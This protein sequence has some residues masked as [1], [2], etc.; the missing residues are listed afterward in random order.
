M[1]YAI[2]K[3]GLGTLKKVLI[4]LYPFTLPKRIVQDRI[5]EEYK[6]FME[7]KKQLETLVS[8]IDHRLEPP[9]LDRR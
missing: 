4:E 7:L 3:G 8:E 2:G 5:V 6:R 9:I 1:E